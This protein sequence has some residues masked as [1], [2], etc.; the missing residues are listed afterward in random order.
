MET[1][2]IP[3]DM[4]QA[5]LG[6][7]DACIR[8]LMCL[9]PRQRAEEQDRLAKLTALLLLLRDKAQRDVDMGRDDIAPVQR[10]RE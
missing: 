3:R 9:G 10:G 2:T 7:L 5:L 1:I 4:F 8:C 6:A